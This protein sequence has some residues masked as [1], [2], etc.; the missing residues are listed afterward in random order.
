M[1]M[2]WILTRSNGPHG[3][4]HDVLASLTVDIKL[5]VLYVKLYVWQSC[6]QVVPKRKVYFSIVRVGIATLRFG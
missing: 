6:V 4:R 5:L 2:I 3:T 1:N